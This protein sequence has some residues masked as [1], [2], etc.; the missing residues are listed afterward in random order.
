[1]R[2]L[3]SFRLN[4][5]ASATCSFIREMG[6]RAVRLLLRLAMFIIPIAGSRAQ[7]GSVQWRYTVAQQGGISF[8]APAL[9]PDGTTVYVGAT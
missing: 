3:Q 9:T 2:C 5:R 7:D 6:R 8:S 1:M 4:F